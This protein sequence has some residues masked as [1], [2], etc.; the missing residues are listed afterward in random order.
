MPKPPTPGIV[1]DNLARFQK[2]F[3]TNRLIFTKE[4][5]LE[6]SYVTLE[7]DWLERACN[8]ARMDERRLSFSEFEDIKVEAQ[9]YCELFR[10]IFEV[11]SD[12]HYCVLLANTCPIAHVDVKGEKGIAVMFNF[13]AMS[14]KEWKT[15]DTLGA[16]TVQFYMSTKG[17]ELFLTHIK[18]EEGIVNALELRRK[19]NM[20]TGES[21]L[22]VRS[23]KYFI[24]TPP[25]IENLS[26]W[27]EVRDGRS[28]KRMLNQFDSP[29]Q[30]PDD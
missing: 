30:Q 9:W 15:W 19:V 11:I 29:E 22:S 7:F 12:G 18:K 5:P 10:M 24:E 4:K 14:L 26:V 2:D 25:T 23:P 17:E 13:P 6:L 21:E 3:V 28:D 27:I 16:S 20:L 8:R 1:F